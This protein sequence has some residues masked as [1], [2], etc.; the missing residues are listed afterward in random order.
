MRRRLNGKKIGRRYLWQN[1]AVYEDGCLT[2]WIE[3]GLGVSV[4]KDWCCGVEAEQK[5]GVMR[6]VALK[7]CAEWNNH[8]CPTADLSCCDFVTDIIDFGNR[9]KL[10]LLDSQRH[11]RTFRGQHPCRG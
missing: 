11:L 10:V 8:S 2:A 7:S 6:L 5:R 1:V 4:R 3:F 9:Y